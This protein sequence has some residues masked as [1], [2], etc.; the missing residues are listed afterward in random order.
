MKGVQLLGDEKIK[1]I[2]YLKT[3]YEYQDKKYTDSMK[4]FICSVK[5]K[6]NDL[7]V[8]IY[9]GFE[10]F[11]WLFE[12]DEFIIECYE[13]GEPVYSLMATDPVIYKKLYVYNEDLEKIEKFMSSVYMTLDETKKENGNITIYSSRCKPPSW[14]KHKSVCLQ[15]L[16]DIYIDKFEQNGLIFSGKTP[17]RRRMEILELS[18]HPCFVAGQ[19]HPEFKS[20]PNKPAPMFKYFI[21]S[22]IKKKYGE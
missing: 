2:E 22:A 17:D 7:E 10:K 21:E 3:N 6:A 16:D 19:F 15:S 5:N 1:F 13:Y 9:P 12:G 11:T 4:N 8:K 14:D 18:G 20:R